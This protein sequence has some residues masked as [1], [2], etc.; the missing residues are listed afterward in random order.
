MVNL[1]EVR[2]RAGAIRGESS[3]WSYSSSTNSHLVQ[4]LNINAGLD[5]QIIVNINFPFNSY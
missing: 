3:C 1:N 2:V 5:L 4:I